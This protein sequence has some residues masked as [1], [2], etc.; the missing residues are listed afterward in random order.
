MRFLAEAPSS[1]RFWLIRKVVVSLAYLGG[2]RLAELRHSK[3]SSLERCPEGFFFTFK[4]A[5]QRGHVKMSK[6]LIPRGKTS[7]GIC[8]AQVIEEYQEALRHD[9]VDMGP[10][11][12]F[13]YTGRP[14]TDSKPSKFIQSPVGE[15]ALR[16]F[17]VDMANLLELPNGEKYTGHCFRR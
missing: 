5:K 15:N 7:T 17:G 6:F 1:N 11:A 4:P 10:E 14:A 2:N 3:Q 16:K 13:L 8:F 12:P 9:N